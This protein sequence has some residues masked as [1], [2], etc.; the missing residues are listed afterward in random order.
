MESNDLID[1]LLTIEIPEALVEKLREISP[2]LIIH[3]K[4]AKRAE[5]IEAD[6]WATTEILYTGR[7]L[8]SSEQAPNLHWIQFHFTG[9]DHAYDTPI[10]Q[11]EGL[12]TTTMSGASATQVAEYILMMMLALGHRMPDLME[13]QRRTSWPKDRWERFVPFELRG[14]SAGIIGYGSIGRQLARLLH[15]LGVKVFATKRDIRHPED[16]GYTPEG[17]GDPGADYVHRLYPAEALRS[18]ARA[19]DF[20]VITVPLTSSNRDLITMDVLS[21][22]KET[23]FLI[24]ISRGGIVN[25]NALITVLKERRI[26]GA[27]LD[28]FPEEPLPPESPLWKLSNVI[29]TPHISGISSHYDERAINL[30]GENIKRYLAGEELLNRVEFERGY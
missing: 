11:R 8:P 28:V 22:M 2:R 23:A 20:L 27:A 16:I 9:I 4:S 18:M 7:I 10:L 24:D 19:S 21:E 26:A 17:F 3:M 30:F 25:H 12:V 29:L 15:P 5:D 13:H 14:S 1:V 6:I